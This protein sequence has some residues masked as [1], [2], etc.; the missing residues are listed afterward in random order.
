MQTRKLLEAWIVW[1][2]VDVFYVGMFLYLAAMGY[3]NWRR[4]MLDD[5]EARG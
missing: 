4:S 5:L 2:A 3:V 1:I